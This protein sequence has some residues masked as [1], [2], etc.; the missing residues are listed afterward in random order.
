MQK[1]LLHPIGIND[2]ESQF[3]RFLESHPQVEIKSIDFSVPF[4]NIPKQRQKKVTVYI[5]FDG[6]AV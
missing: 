3:N 2:F 5:F 6:H 4:I 1:Y